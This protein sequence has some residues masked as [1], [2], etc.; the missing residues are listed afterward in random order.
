M[1]YDYCILISAPG[2]LNSSALGHPSRLNFVWPTILR[3]IFGK[4]V[5]PV[6]HGEFKLPLVKFFRM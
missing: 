1:V 5:D 3:K 4:F 2:L 6:L